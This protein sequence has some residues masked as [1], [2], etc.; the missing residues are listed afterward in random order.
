MIAKVDLVASYQGEDLAFG[1]HLQVKAFS[2]QDQGPIEFQSD[3]HW[4]Q[5]VIIE[6]SAGNVTKPSIMPSFLGATLNS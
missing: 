4:M 2:Y 1:T 3:C 5:S 6:S